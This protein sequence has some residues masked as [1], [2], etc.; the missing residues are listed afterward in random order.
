M[1]CFSPAQSSKQPL[2]P[3]LQ[4]SP[5][6]S[7]SV[8]VNPPRVAPTRSPP[9]EAAAAGAAACNPLAS[10]RHHLT[11]HFR[12]W[13]E[14]GA[15]LR[16][17]TPPAVV[18]RRAP[19]PRPAS[20]LTLP[21]TGHRALHSARCHKH[22]LTELP[23]LRLRPAGQGCGSCPAVGSRE[24]PRGRCGARPGPLRPPEPPLARPHSLP[25]GRRH[26]GPRSRHSR[27]RRSGAADSSRL[28]APPQSLPAH[29]GASAPCRDPAPL[30]WRNGERTKKERGR[31]FF[32]FLVF[33]GEWRKCR[34]G[35]G[36]PAPP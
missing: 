12:P 13:C 3:K 28:K 14:H 31:L 5:H 17:E 1:L 2:L 29:P 4:V 26:L 8:A 23:A 6:T 22:R 7:C 33:F 9:P 35:S 10:P 36:R 15:F 21:P 30:L 27:R 34:S 16:S 24:P 25:A 11:A 20:P 32:V 18:S 19:L